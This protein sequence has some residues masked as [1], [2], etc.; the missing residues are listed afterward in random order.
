MAQPLPLPPPGF[1]DLSV[2]DQI[3]YLQTLWDRIAANADQVSLH[4]WQK[5]LITERLAAHR[6]APHEAQPW[7]EVMDRLQDRLKRASSR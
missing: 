4:E 7:E 5:Q 6:A 2:D 3:E 1:D